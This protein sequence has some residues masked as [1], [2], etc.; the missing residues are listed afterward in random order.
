[1]HFE[2]ILRNQSTGISNVYINEGFRSFLVAI[3]NDADKLVDKMIQLGIKKLIQAW[4]P[5]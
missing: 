2:I 5:M 3:S 1:M 4:I